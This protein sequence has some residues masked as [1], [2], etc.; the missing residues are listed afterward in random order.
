MRRLVI[1]PL[2]AVALLGIAGAA[3]AKPIKAEL[4][5]NMV[6]VTATNVA[7]DRSGTEEFVKLVLDSSHRTEER[8][9]TGTIHLK[10]EGRTT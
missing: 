6:K 7:K 8:L 9:V 5:Q 1:V 10:K 2:A 3:F 4:K